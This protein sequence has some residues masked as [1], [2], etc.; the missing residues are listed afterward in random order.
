MTVVLLLPTCY[1]SSKALVSL[2]SSTLP[3]NA[4]LAVFDAVT[5]N[6]ALV[7]PLSDIIAL[8]KER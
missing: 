2:V 6:T 8:C 3:N 4:K 1:C 5:S 7:L